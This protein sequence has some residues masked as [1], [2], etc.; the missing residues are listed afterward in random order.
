MN[1]TERL[2]VSTINNGFR[3]FATEKTAA[4]ETIAMPEG[5]STCGFQG[6]ITAHGESRERTL[7]VDFSY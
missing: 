5:T 4:S 2:S 7:T 1:R 3:R 6:N